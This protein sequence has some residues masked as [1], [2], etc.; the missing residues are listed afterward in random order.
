MDIS[1]IIGPDRWVVTTILWPSII[2][3]YFLL[4]SY[5]YFELF[6]IY[7]RVA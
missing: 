4:A 7:V 5:G 1:N 3:V 2:A 6:F